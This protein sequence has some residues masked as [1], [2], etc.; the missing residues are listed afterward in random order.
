MIKDI[1]TRVRE[2]SLH[3]YALIFLSGFT[4]L[5]YEVVWQ[6]YLTYFLGSHG[7]ATA[8]ILAI[9][10]LFLS[11]GYHFFGR[12]SHRF[13]HNKLLL[14]GIIEG[15]IGVYS[16]LSPSVFNWLAT[17]FPF[18][19]TEPF[20]DLLF[21]MLFTTCLIGF[22]TFLMGGTIPVLADALISSPSQSH[23]IHAIIY[24]TNTA[25]AFGGTICAGFLFLEWWGLPLTLMYTGLIN[26]GI[27]GYI[28]V[29]C[30]GNPDSY[31]GLQVNQG[32]LSLNIFNPSTPSVQWAILLVSCLSG[33][34]VFSL[35]SLIIRMAGISL[36]STTYT[37]SII[38]A[39]FILA[40]ALGSLFISLFQKIIHYRIL[41]I[42]QTLLLFSWFAVYLSIPNWPVW[43]T[44]IHFAVSPFYFNFPVYWAGVFA[45]FLFLLFIPVGLM[46]MN[47][48]LLFNY[49]KSASTHYS[50]TVGRI[51][52][53]N[54]LASTLGASIGGYLLFYYFRFEEVF[55]INLILIAISIPL[56]AYLTAQENWMRVSSLGLSVIAFCAALLLPS[57]G[58][59]TFS[60]PASLTAIP[61][62]PEANIRTERSNHLQTLTHVA[63]LHGPDSMV[64]IVEDE[65]GQATLY[66]NAQAISHTKIDR[67]V[68]ALNA[69]LAMYLTPDVQHAF[70]VGLGPGL[71]PALTTHHHGIQSVD[72]AEI[73]KAT[74]DARDYFKKFHGAYAA[75][76]DLL[77]IVHSDAF[78]VLRQSPKTYDLIV[79]EPAHPWIT[80][81]ENLYSLEFL[82]LAKTK[83]TQ[84]GIYAQWFP[85]VGLD[86]DTMMTIINTFQIVFPWVTLWSPQDSII[87]ILAS[88]TAREPH[89]E[90]FKTVYENYIDLFQEFDLNHYLTPLVLQILSQPALSDLLTHFQ[91]S[92][93]IEFP[94]IAFRAGRSLFA[95]DSADLRRF[96]LKV[97]DPPMTRK[98]IG[99]CMKNYQ[100]RKTVNSFSR[101]SSPF[102]NLNRVSKPS[103]CDLSCSIKKPSRKTMTL[104]FQIRPLKVTNIS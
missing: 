65:D 10:F 9:F 47:L 41:I 67:H 76:E 79:S 69:L 46:G 101:G 16:F 19:S 31:Q 26:I 64:D 53:L 82:T 99:L 2:L 17:S 86:D 92:Q 20:P 24:G 57:W 44:R 13:H 14:Y 93:S 77:H 75:K 83:M 22:P 18:W 72:V 23:R 104:K 49:L 29:H 60:P 3:I 100:K 43:F 39:A 32:Q 37:F 54:T 96:I 4:G 81:V 85:L 11:L 103:T 33:F 62:T 91:G 90:R 70:F 21:S 28:Y 45:L 74:I 7:K 61:N 36:G 30:K 68:R 63:N 59:Q 12:Y 8:L 1:V 25:G 50:S 34:Y 88:P 58:D 35:E 27:C 71:G 87:L 40:L 56:V 6:K 48:P 95:S 78:K 15:L 5:V 55:Q 51:Y 73:S 66:V 98:T 38:V 80:G 89:L 97:I 102:Q 42:V 84:H 52:S 94:K